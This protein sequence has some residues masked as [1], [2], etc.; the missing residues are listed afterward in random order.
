MSGE[1]SR[2]VLLLLFV[3]IVQSWSLGGA[4]Q[5]PEPESKGPPPSPR[6]EAAWIKSYP[7]L[8]PPPGQIRAVAVALSESGHCV[9]VAGDGVLE[10]LSSS[11]QLMWSWKYGAINR[12]ITPGALAV[13]PP[14][15]AIALAGDSSYKYI[16]F[17]NR[18]GSAKSAHITS[19]PLGV[20]FD[21]RG[22]LVA[23]GTGGRDV[24]LFTASGELKWKRI[25]Q[26]GACCLVGRLSFS[27]DNR[28]LLIRE[29]GSGVLRLDGT[30]VWI[31][32]DD[33]MNTARDLQT[34]VA[35]WQP[36][37]G[38]G[39]GHIKCLDASGKELWSEYASIPGAAISSRGDKI[40]ARV[41]LNQSP[42]E[43]NYNDDEHE[44]SLQVFSRDGT[45]LKTLPQ[46]A[47]PI[48]ISSDEQ[49]VVIRTESALQA[50]D[51]DGKVLSDIPINPHVYN[52]ILIGG[53]TSVIVI[54][55]AIVAPQLQWY[56][57]E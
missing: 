54:F 21:H 31:A 22:E 5:T 17:A 56:K 37:H 16:W 18:R 26:E 10:V 1:T 9:A 38:P 33:A 46:N 52:H 29:G 36:S 8:E 19:T 43:H 30:V 24:L 28:F 12:F 23:A 53:D 6:L 11:G 55:R 51:L 39:I 25:L 13:S 32:G 44:T 15:D 50:I 3:V 4:P 45:I 27:E 42:T 14:C 20:A 48:S 47:T 40:I 57:L 7:N 34:F 41:N 2:R 35:W 49:R